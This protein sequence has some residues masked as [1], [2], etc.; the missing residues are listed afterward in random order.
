MPGVAEA[1]VPQGTITFL[2]PTGTA[3]ATDNIDVWVRLTL[4]PDSEPLNI[5]GGVPLWAY[6]PN[7][8][9]T[10]SSAE[11]YL[12][13]TSVNTNTYY[14]CSGTFTNVCSP[15]AYAFEFNTTP[16]Q[17][18]FYLSDISV[19]PGGSYDY[20]FGTFKPVGGV[21]PAG[22]YTF[23]NSGATLQATGLGYRA[24]RNADGS[25]VTDP[26]TGSIVYEP[27]LDDEGK[28]VLEPVQK[29]VYVPLL[30]A[31]GDPLFD[32]SG[33][34]L[35]EQAIDPDTGGLLYD[36]FGNPVPLQATDPDTGELL[37]TT[38][39]QPRPAVVEVF[40]GSVDIASNGCDFGSSCVAFTREVS[41]VPEASTLGMALAGLLLMGT[42]W[43][44]RRRA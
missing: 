12:S 2:Q 30:D 5:A 15:G 23:F 1:A 7:D 8:F 3:G 27:E 42:T 10:S 37:F 43:V 13:V 38:V 41:A 16:T 44:V 6:S 28:P 40:S 29:P 19:A 9:N 20:L 4:N 17:S 25:L 33:K 26:V 11:F 21:A 18:F 22:A 14:T 35:Y 34:P 32:L 31:N 36:A 39:Y 24:L